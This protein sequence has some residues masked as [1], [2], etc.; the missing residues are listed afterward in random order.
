MYLP[1]VSLIAA[2]LYRVI[3]GVLVDW[4]ALQHVCATMIAAGMVDA[5]AGARANRSSL[6]IIW[7]GPSLATTFQGSLHFITAPIR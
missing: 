7:L 2:T 4:T 1:A 6:K 3:V 5:T